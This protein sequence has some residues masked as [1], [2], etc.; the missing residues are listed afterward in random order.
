MSGMYIPPKCE[1][2]HPNCFA[3]RTFPDACSALMDTDFPKRSDCPFF[4]SAEQYEEEKDKKN[5][6]Q[7]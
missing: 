3:H 6:Y 5:G 2:N 1:W 7:Y 4:K